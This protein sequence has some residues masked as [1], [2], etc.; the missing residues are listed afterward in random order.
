MAW[1]LMASA[2]ELPPDPDEPELPHAASSD[3]ADTPSAPAPARRSSVA[4]VSGSSERGSWV[5]TAAPP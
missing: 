1:P 5:F 2:A 3:A 4:R